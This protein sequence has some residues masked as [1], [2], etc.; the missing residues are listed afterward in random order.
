MQGSA[1]DPSEGVLFR[2][3]ALHLLSFSLA[4]YSHS[5]A[6]QPRPW[7]L[8]RIVVYVAVLK[9]L[10]GIGWSSGRCCSFAVQTALEFGYGQE[11]Y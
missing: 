1:L 8:Y 3:A 5:D 9:E 6:S 2:A 10:S 11:H 7:E 4:H